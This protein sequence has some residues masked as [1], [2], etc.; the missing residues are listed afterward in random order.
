MLLNY[1]TQTSRFAIPCCTLKHNIVHFS[2]L[3][4]SFI[5]FDVMFAKNR[6]LHYRFGG[7]ILLAEI[8]PTSVAAR[9]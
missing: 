6:C 5:I 8:V 9:F 3:I 7:V 4:L 2:F 1:F